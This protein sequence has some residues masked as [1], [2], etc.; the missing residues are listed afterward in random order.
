MLKPVMRIRGL[1]I[2]KNKK[3]FNNS[4]SQK[5]K[6]LRVI[7]KNQESALGF[8][9]LGFLLITPRILIIKLNEGSEP[10]R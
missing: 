3:I 5:I 4:V 1:K 7:N 10:K 2:K 9:I 8:R 6:I